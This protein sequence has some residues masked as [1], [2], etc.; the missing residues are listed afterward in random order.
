MK[1]YIENWEQE[2][3][4]IENNLKI[5]KGFLNVAKKVDFLTNY[6]DEGDTIKIIFSNVKAEKTKIIYRIIFFIG[7]K[8]SEYKVID[9]NE[10]SYLKIDVLLP[11]TFNNKEIKEDFIYFKNDEE[12][13][14]K[15]EKLMLGSDKLYSEYKMSILNRSLGTSNQ[16]KKQNKI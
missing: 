16:H 5:D 6:F 9:F 14:N 8:N 11:E 4:S 15:F 13:I 10:L 1:T 2:I 7:Y 12:G 3:N